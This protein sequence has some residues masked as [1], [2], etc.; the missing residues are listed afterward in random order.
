M[1]FFLKGI[2]EQLEESSPACQTD[3]TVNAVMASEE[4]NMKKRKNPQ[5]GER[6][7]KKKRTDG[8][9]IPASHS[10]TVESEYSD[11]D[12]SGSISG[13]DYEEGE[14]EVKQAIK[15]VEEHFSEI[16]K[17]RLKAQREKNAFCSLKRSEVQASFCIE[18]C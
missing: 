9:D 10:N 17:E 3:L 13:L 6:H 14:D 2:K 8:D 12:S 15:T 4:T 11:S 1:F 7:S 18:R 5:G 16:E